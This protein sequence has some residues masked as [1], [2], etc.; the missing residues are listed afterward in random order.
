MRAGL[1]AW[2]ATLAVSTG[3]LRPGASPL[4][5][6]SAY[7]T[8]SAAGYFFPPSII[9]RITGEDGQVLYQGLDIGIQICTPAEAQTVTAV[10]QR[11]A[12]EG[13]A[14]LAISYPGVAAKTGTSISG[15]WYAGFD[16]IHRLLTWTES[17]FSPFSSR[18]FPGKAVSAKELA[19][20]IWGLLRKPQVGFQELFTVFGGADQMSVR[21][22]LWV[23]N[24]FQ[25]T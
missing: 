24:Y 15:G 13:T 17:D 4:A 21:D 23:E 12:T 11:V 7:S 2:D 5:A 3:A 19:N 22:L 9:S 8:F 1:P 6:C 10:L 16:G 14:R 18:Y 20:R 25:T